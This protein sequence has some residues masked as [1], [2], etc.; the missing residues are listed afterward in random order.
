MSRLFNSREAKAFVISRI[1]QESLR[2]GTPLAEPER[3]QLDFSEDPDELDG[4]PGE[5]AEPVDPEGYER[6]IAQLVRGADREARRA[7]GEE[8]ES[9]RSAIRLLKQR[10]NYIGVMIDRAGLRPPGDFLKLIATAAAICALAVAVGVVLATYDLPRGNAIQYI[11][12]GCLGIAVVW[13]LAYQWKLR[14][15]GRRTRE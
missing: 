2:R 14:A 9:W 4:V 12:A 3:R 8:Y 1:V 13:W 6:K 11:W 7:G 10:D 15:S 5:I